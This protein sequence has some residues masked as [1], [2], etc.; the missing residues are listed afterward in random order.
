MHS[1]PV[2]ACA[3]PGCRGAGWGPIDTVVLGVRVGSP[4]HRGLP[5]FLPDCF[6]VFLSF[7]SYFITLELTC[8]NITDFVFFI[9]PLF[10]LLF[11]WFFLGQE[12]ST[13]AQ[14][15]FHVHCLVFGIKAAVE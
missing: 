10:V 15:A 6:S 12:H 2:S 13:Y 5:F 8:Q 4:Q 3:V 7:F 9:F 11:V 14:N 1:L